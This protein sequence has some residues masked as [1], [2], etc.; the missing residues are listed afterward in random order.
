MSY[1]KIVRWQN[2]LLFAIILFGVRY[3][4]LYNELEHLYLSDAQFLVLVTSMLCIIA[5]CYV[6]CDTGDTITDE[7][8]KPE[9]VMIF[10]KIPD[11]NVLRLYIIL[12]LVGVGVGFYFANYIGRPNFAFL[13]LVVAGTMYMYAGNIK[14][15][16]VINN[17]IPALFMPLLV[18]TP[19]VF[20]VIPI[21]NE[22]NTA[23]YASYFKVVL[24]LSVAFFIL[25]F[26]REI[27]KDVG[28]IDGDC[29]SDENTLPIVLGS[30]RAIW[31][32]QGLLGIFVIL[33]FFYAYKY[34]WPN[35]LWWSLRALLFLVLAPVL[36]LLFML[37]GKPNKKAIFWYARVLKYLLLM[38]TFVAAVMVYNIKQ[39]V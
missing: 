28:S 32:V 21:L 22:S 6:E 37:H 17:L 39:N 14:N 7:I 13:F 9:R 19:I 38:L 31:I 15:I 26:A 29:N 11:A 30:K 5:A 34:L 27:L 23:F 3:G 20:D 35:E 33:T 10:K 25:T 12:N 1:L 18:I 2:L 4:F 36:Y 16:L 24:D 8:N